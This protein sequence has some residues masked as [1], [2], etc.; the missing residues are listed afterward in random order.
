[1]KATT[2]ADQFPT[3]IAGLPASVPSQLV[4]LG[5]RGAVRA[6][7][8]ARHEADR[9]RDRAHALVQRLDP[10]ADAQG[11][12]GV[13]GRRRRRER[14]R[15]RRDGALARAAARQPLRRNA[16]DAA[17]DGDRRE[18]PVPVAVP[19]SGRLLVPPAHPRGLR[20]GAGPLREHPRR[21]DR[22]GVLAAGQPR[23][24]ADARR[25]LDRGRQGRR[26]QPLG[27][28]VRGDGPLRQH[29]ARRWRLRRSTLD[30]G[31]A[32]WCAST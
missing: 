4:E 5:R 14:G 23:G 8:R 6:A 25:R 10:R 9:R 20:P 11:A 1:M 32:R 24:V 29:D 31:A 22:P 18:L 26:V 12:A 27:D 13:G 7:D 28:D 17:A 30:V 15:P 3:E 19:R 16:R 21:P 2:S